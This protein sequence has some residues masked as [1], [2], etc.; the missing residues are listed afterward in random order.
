MSFYFTDTVEI[1][2]ITRDTTYGVETKGTP[3]TVSCRV[4]ERNKL[5]KNDKGQDL[6]ANIQLFLPP[7]ET[8]F[9]GDMFS[10]KTKNGVTY[11]NSTK[12]FQVKEIFDNVGFGAM[13][14]EVWA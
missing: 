8:I 5:Y 1:T 9:V 4:E 14:L 12:E 10:I 6:V 11:R 7:D 3:R 2:N 13:D